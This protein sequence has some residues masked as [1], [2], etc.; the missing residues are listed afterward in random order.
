[1]RG[2]LTKL[3]LGVVDRAARCARPAT[4]A[5]C[6]RSEQARIPMANQSQVGQSPARR[7]AQCQPKALLAASNP[8]FT[9]TRRAGP[10]SSTVAG[11]GPKQHP[12]W[13]LACAFLGARLIRG[14]SCAG[15]PTGALASGCR[16]APTADAYRGVGMRTVRCWSEV[17]RA[18]NAPHADS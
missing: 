16:L 15:A 4:V 8:C 10:N 3:P 2:E 12:P 1:M 17:R 9:S 6:A 11:V 14:R 18:V 7:L 5:P 13:V